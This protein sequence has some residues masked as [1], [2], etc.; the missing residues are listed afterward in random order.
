MSNS[1]INKTPID[2]ITNRKIGGQGPSRY[3]LRLEQDGIDSE[4]LNEVLTAHWI[5]PEHLRVDGFANC[6]VERGEAMLNLIGRA[7]GKQIGSGG[8][9]FWNALTSAGY[10]D[11]YEDGE[12]ED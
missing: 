12:E 1:V 5:N 9:V 8:E 2:A 10:V 4:K 3:L 11:D 7:M 6:F